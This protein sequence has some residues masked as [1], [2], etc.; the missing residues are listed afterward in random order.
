[1]VPAKDS[2]QVDLYWS[3]ET[4]VNRPVVVFVHV[5]AEEELVGQSDLPPGQGYWIPQWWRPGLILQDR[6]IIQMAQPY[7]VSRQQLQVGIYDASSRQ[8]LPVY[9]PAGTHLGDAWLWQP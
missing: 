9:T 2:M 6:H 8:R 4:G 5:V 7:D 3:T 1:M